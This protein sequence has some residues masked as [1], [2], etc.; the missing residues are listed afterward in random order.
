MDALRGLFQGPGSGTIVPREQPEPPRESILWGK[1]ALPA[2]FARQSH[3]RI[4]GITGSGK[5]HL[6]KLFLL[7]ALRE[8]EQNDAK[9]VVFE[10]KR[11][12]YAW[13]Q[14]VRRQY[15]YSFPVTYFMPSDTRGA[16]LEFWRDY[17]S[18]QDSRT[19]ANAFFPPDP[20][21]RDQFWSKSLRTIFAQV[22]DAIKWQLGYADLRLACLVLE[23]EELTRALL[24]TDPY[25]VQAR[26]LIEQGHTKEVDKTSRDIG[27]TIQTRVA[28]MKVLAAHLELARQEGRS[29]SLSR[30]VNLP[31]AGAL[32]VSKDP[33]Y[34]LVQDPMNG[35]IFLRLMELLDRLQQDAARRVFIVIDEFPMLAGDKPCPG[36]EKMLLLLRSRGVSLLFTYQAHASLKRIYGEEMADEIVGEVANVIYLKQGDVNSAGYAARDLGCERGFDETTTVG[37][38]GGMSGAV[39]NSGWSIQ[40]QKH[41]YDRPIHSATELMNGLR[42]SDEEWGLEGFAKSAAVGAEPYYFTYEPAEIA[43][44]PKTSPDFKDYE[45]RDPDLGEDEGGDPVKS[46]RRYIEH[47]RKT[48]RVERLLDEEKDQLLGRTTEEGDREKCR[49]FLDG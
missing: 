20:N 19:L 41:P 38:S 44:I 15:N 47:M 32:V 21:E 7:D 5:S 48:Q 31:G 13:V 36:I 2:R 40:K 12:F 8:V 3:Y 43:A 27:R 11:E 39:P 37:V 33:V 10:P 46:F 1:K 28:E 35:I 16:T 25:L 30:F 18:D 45:R 29:F 23:D 24:K 6:T 26:V 14:T 49:T 17:L 42:P 22:F 34:S 4:S 9:L